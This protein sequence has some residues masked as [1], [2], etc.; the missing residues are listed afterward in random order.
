MSSTSKSL[1]VGHN[2]GHFH[3]VG[4]DGYNQFNEQTMLHFDRPNF[5]SLA[6]FTSSMRRCGLLVS[7]AWVCHVCSYVSAW[8][9]SDVALNGDRAMLQVCDAHDLVHVHVHDRFS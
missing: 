9:D 6:C 3:L 2:F 7:G 5:D 8:T 4:K 1:A